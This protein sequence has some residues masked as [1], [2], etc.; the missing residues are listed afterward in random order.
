MEK[1][2]K[3]WKGGKKKSALKRSETKPYFF[4]VRLAKPL[5][6]SG[7]RGFRGPE[8]ALRRFNKEGLFFGRPSHMPAHKSNYCPWQTEKQGCGEPRE[9]PVSG[10]SGAHSVLEELQRSGRRREKD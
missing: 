8:K 2:G 10:R 4:L 3:R 5:T 1:E 7:P 9:R 6:P